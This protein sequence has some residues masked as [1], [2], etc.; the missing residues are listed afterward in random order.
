[1]DGDHLPIG[2]IH[3][4]QKLSSEQS[5]PNHNHEPLYLQVV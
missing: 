3:W 5:S 2:V 4:N 1:M